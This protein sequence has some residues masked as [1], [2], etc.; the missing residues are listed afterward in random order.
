MSDTDD[1]IDGLDGRDGTVLEGLRAAVLMLAGS[2]ARLAAHDGRAVRRLG[3]SL[4]ATGLGG[5]GLVA[6]AWAMAAN[7]CPWWHDTHLPLMATAA[8]LALLA[9][10]GR[11]WLAAPGELLAPGRADGGLVTTAV[12]IVLALCLLGIVPFHREPSNLPAWLAWTRPPE[13]YRVLL[14]MGMW[15]AWAMMTPTH[16]CRHR[17]DAPPLVAAFARTHPLPVTAGWMAVTL[18]VSLWELSFLSLPWVI[19]PGAAGL[20]AG[21]AGAVALCRA[22]GGISRRGLLAA[23]LAT[24]LAFLLGYLVGKSHLIH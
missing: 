5:G 3:V 21:G 8:V 4:A 22:T 7:A 1:G 2:D 11:R 23:N 24:Q 13:E 10:G 17:P 18:A 12:M 20:L 14:A 15:G 16:F 6:V 9:L 19:L